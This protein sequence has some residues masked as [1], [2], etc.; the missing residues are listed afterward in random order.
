MAEEKSKRKKLEQDIAD[1]LLKY[2]EK[3]GYTVE[4]LEVSWHMNITTNIPHYYAVKAK[5]D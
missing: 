5:V 4:K 3:T 2:S 1:L